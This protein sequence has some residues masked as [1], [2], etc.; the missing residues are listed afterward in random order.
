MYHC[1]PHFGRGDNASVIYHWSA[2]RRL[3]PQGLCINALVGKKG[4]LRLALGCSSLCLFLTYCRIYFSLAAPLFFFMLFIFFHTTKRNE[5][6]PSFQTLGSVLATNSTV[7]R[8]FLLTVTFSLC[9]NHAN[10]W[11]KSRSKSIKSRNQ[12]GPQSVHQVATE[13]DECNV[14]EV[15]N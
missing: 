9:A 2:A 4:T 6:T 7:P 14:N 11:N 10:S 8:R 5:I 1:P 12:R 15:S 3:I 13:L